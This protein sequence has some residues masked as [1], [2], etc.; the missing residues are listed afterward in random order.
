MGFFE[1][2]D[3][4]SVGIKKVD[5]QHRKLVGYLNQLYESMKAGKGSETMGAVIK[6][7]VEYTKNHF[8]T[9]ESLLKLYNYPEYEAHKNKHEKMTGHVLHLKR[10]YDSGEL[11]SPIQITNFLKDWLSKHILESDKQYGAFLNQKGVQ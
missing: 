5:E 4:Y 2:K 6:D 7:L 8:A 10:K 11:A 3:D 1:W 9:E